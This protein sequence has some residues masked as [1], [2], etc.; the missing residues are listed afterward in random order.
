MP[1]PP[2]LPIHQYDPANTSSYPGSGSTLFDLGTATAINLTLNN[3]AYNNVNNTFRLNGTLTSNIRSAEGI[4]TGIGV[5]DFTVQFWYQYFGQTGLYADD[6]VLQLGTRSGTYGGTNFTINSGQLQL[7]NPGVNS[8]PTGW[9]PVVGTWY[10][11]TLTVNSSNFNTLY[12][13]GVSTFTGTIPYSSQGPN[14]S[15][16]FGAA[17]SNIGQAANEAIG[18]FQ[19][20]DRVITTTEITDY[21]NSTK[22]RFPVYSYDFSNPSTYP[23]TGNTVYSLTNTLNLPIVNATF[24]GS[25]VQKYFNFDGTGDYIGKTGVTGLGNTFTANMWYQLTAVNSTP[26]NLWTAG[27]NNAAG[28]NPGFG[29]NYPTTADLIW[30]YSF[31]VGTTVIPDVLVANTWQMATVTADGTTTK[32][33]LDG[34]LAGSVAQGTGNWATGGFAIG[35]GVDGSGNITTGSDCFLGKFALLDFYNVALGSTEVANIYADLY[36]RFDNLVASYDFSDPACYSGSGNTVYDLSGS[37]I[38]LTI[39]GATYVSDGQASYFS[40]DG[41][42]YIGKNGNIVGLGAT[43]T[44][45]IWLQRSNTNFGVPF[46]CGIDSPSGTAPLVVVNSATSLQFQFNYGVGINNTNVDLITDWNLV[47]IVCDGTNDKIYVNG[48]LLSTAS[49]GVGTWPSTGGL[50]FGSNVDSSGNPNT[51]SY[52]GKIG[53]A[54][55][56]NTAFTG[57]DVTNYYD[58][59]VSRFFPPPPYSGNVGGRQFNQGFNG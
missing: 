45:N 20:Y 35:A 37:G 58:S 30:G 12:I 5:N 9:F 16:S 36:P 24:G 2:A 55:F 6:I 26:R 7:E 23:G 42:N 50:Y 43:F 49:Q 8:Y 40:F 46:A 21:Y 10:L 25:G 1:T 29:L 15:I 48:S 18:P 54:Q 53:L 11:V 51:I 59:T 13:N 38:D 32:I 28:T 17:I 14:P 56:Y 27:Y 52:E 33:Y 19:L 34:V 22:A 4:S 39:N 44:T 3:T 31:G 41:T 57:T 47:T